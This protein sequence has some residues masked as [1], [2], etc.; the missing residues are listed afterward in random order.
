M[1]LDFYNLAVFRLEQYLCFTIFY[2]VPSQ[3]LVRMWS[4]AEEHVRV[5]AFLCLRKVAAA[6]PVLFEFLLKVS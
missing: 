5:I 2:F 4:S 3:R 1:Q 6:I